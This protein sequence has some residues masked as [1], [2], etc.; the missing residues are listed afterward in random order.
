MR[1]GRRAR[2]SA[3][4]LCSF[5]SH[6]IDESRRRGSD[7]TGPPPPRPPHHPIAAAAAAPGTPAPVALLAA[8]AFFAAAVVVQ[9]P[10]PSSASGPVSATHPTHRGSSG[11]LFDSGA[12]PRNGVGAGRR[13]ASTQPRAAPAS[14]Q[15]RTHNCH[16]QQRREAS[17]GSQR[18]NGRAHVSAGRRAGRGAAAPAGGTLGAA[19]PPSRRGWPATP[20][21]P[22]RPPGGKNT[23][24]SGGWRAA[25]GGYGG[26]GRGG[27]PPGGARC[28]RRTRGRPGPRRGE[29]GSRAGR[30]GPAGAGRGGE[31]RGGSGCGRRAGRGEG[32][33][34]GGRVGGVAAGGWRVGAG[35]RARAMTGMHPAVMALTSL[36]SHLAGERPRQAQTLL[37][38]SRCRRWKRRG[39]RGRVPLAELLS[40]PLPDGREA[41]DALLEHLEVPSAGRAG[42]APPVRP[43]AGG[44]GE[45]RK[46]RERSGG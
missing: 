3:W 40:A 30:G 37:N 21:T 8:V 1:S 2:P 34:G 45:R 19:A 9:L 29:P 4:V 25:S 14:Q 6:L 15:T 32:R 18:A 22:A 31:G 10:P 26:Q 17:G 12:A 16:A 36:W 33:R 42:V 35:W 20:C 7:A 23:G 28:P 44:R 13:Q 27:G 39:E 24:G 46:G 5:V 11:G 43:V 38:A 41:E